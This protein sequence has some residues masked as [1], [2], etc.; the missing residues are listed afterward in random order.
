M[1]ERLRLSFCYLSLKIMFAVNKCPDTFKEVEEASKRI[2]CGKDM[3]GKNQYM[4]LPDVDK[5]SLY[6]FCHG[7]IMG[8]KEK[9]S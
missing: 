6:E 2:G 9:G 7:G 5:T 8:I 3:F 4:C 1:N